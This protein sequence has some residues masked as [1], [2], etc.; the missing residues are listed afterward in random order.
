MWKGST[1]VVFDGFESVGSVGSDISGEAPPQEQDT[2]HSLPAWQTIKR[3]T[4]S[5]Q[6]PTIQSIWD[7]SDW[8]V[9]E[10]QS[11]EA[12]SAF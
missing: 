5:G 3:R 4:G 6:V 7:L 9:Y 11:L 2:F 10:R 1:R 12:I 8:L